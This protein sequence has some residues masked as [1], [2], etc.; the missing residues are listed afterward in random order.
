MSRT[1]QN[2]PAHHLAE[3]AF[4]SPI[5]GGDLLLGRLAIPNRTTNSLITNTAKAGAANRRSSTANGVRYWPPRSVLARGHRPGIV[6]RFPIT[7]NP[8][9]QCNSKDTSMS[10]TYA[11]N[12]SLYSYFPFGVIW[13][14]DRGRRSRSFSSSIGMC[15][16]SSGISLSGF[17]V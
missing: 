9:G 13:P 16:C 15:S 4:V 6:Y 12:G 8:R 1:T 5:G 3:S 11:A 10:I 17:C 7:I 14:G 2:R